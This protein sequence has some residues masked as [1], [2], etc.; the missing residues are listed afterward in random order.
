M[1]WGMSEKLGRVRYKSN[2]QE[3]FL[4]HSVAQSTHMSDDT[5]KLIDQEVRKLVED[6]EA[7]A[8]KLILDNADQF[9]SI[10]KALLE[11]ETL[12]G[13]E[14]RALMEG[15]QPFRPDDGGNSTPKASGVPSA[16]KAS[17]K[18]PDAE[19][20]AEPEPQPGN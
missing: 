18:R 8:R 5:A 16:G 11:Y 1:E 4:G 15:Q 6:G 19:P 3:V 9:E 14:L 13:D 10:G 20:D 12:T 2:E 17:K 7:M